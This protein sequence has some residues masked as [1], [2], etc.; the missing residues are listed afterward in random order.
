MLSDFAFSPPYLVKNSNNE[1]THNK[2]Q[3]KALNLE[4]T[5]YLQ[6]ISY[7][8]SNMAGKDHYNDANRCF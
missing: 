7:L 8:R 4:L 1:K 2:F 5:L 6:R 3:T